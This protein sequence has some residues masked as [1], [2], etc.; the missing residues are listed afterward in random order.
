MASYSRHYFHDARGH[1]YIDKP[2]ACTITLVGAA[3]MTQTELDHYGELFASAIR[4][5]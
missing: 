5:S 1:V 4:D 2:G 3:D